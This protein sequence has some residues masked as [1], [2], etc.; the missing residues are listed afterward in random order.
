[1]GRILDRLDALG[2]REETL[3]LFVSDH[4]DFRGDHAM[5]KKD[6]V[7]YDPLL[8]IPG[9][10]RW[11]GVLPS[12]AVRDA[13][14]EQV[15]L[16]PTLAELAGVAVPKG[17]Q[18]W[19]FAAV[20]RGESEVHR[21]AV[22]GEVCPPDFENPYPDYAAFI[23]EWE[24]ARDIEGHPLR[25]TASFNVPGEPVKMVRT[26]SHKYV[27]YRSGEEEL[28]DLVADPGEQR[29]LA[30]DPEYRSVGD[31]LR[32]RLLEWIVLTEDARDPR[33]D[34]RLAQTHPWGEPTLLPAAPGAGGNG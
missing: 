23:A 11:P 18:G 19:S 15:D 27:W 26:A 10:L 20:L 33:D 7:L 29:N 5:V 1:V 17:V 22:F 34:Y 6:L 25:W 30:V 9:L 24:R 16:Y 14:C 2:C 28:Y 12:G 4:G 13:L 3:V 32:L 21:E 31:A 8:H